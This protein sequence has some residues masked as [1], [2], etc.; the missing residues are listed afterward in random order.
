VQEQTIKC[1]TVSTSTIGQMIP[2]RPLFSIASDGATS[3]NNR[4]GGTLS[5][6]KSSTNIPAIVFTGASS[7]TII[8]AGD[9]YFTT[10]VGG[11]RRFTVLANGN[12]GIGTLNPTDALSVNG[13]IR[14]VGIK[15]ES[16]NWPDYVFEPTYQLADIDSVKAFIDKHQHLPEIPSKNDIKKNGLNVGEMQNILLKKIEELTLYMLNLKKSNEGLKAE[17]KELKKG[18]LEIA[19][20]LQRN[21]IY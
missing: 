9:S 13:M 17:N 1:K 21:L 15:V 4:S 7:S 8:E 10:Y 6:H 20:K 18:Q 2:V 16:A 11:S 19:A 12:V 14:A 5:L 3:I